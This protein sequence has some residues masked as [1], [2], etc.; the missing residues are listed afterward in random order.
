MFVVV[1]DVSGKGL[2]ASF[3]MSKIQTMI[4][5]FSN[6]TKSPKE[7]LV[8]VN[9]KIFGKISKQSFITM[10]I[11]FIDVG[12]RSMKLCRAG[13]TPIIKFNN[14]VIQFIKPN[15]IGV[16]LENGLIFEESL[17]EIEIPLSPKDIFVFS[18]DGVNEA[19][20]DNNDLFGYD[21]LIEVIKRNSNNSSSEIVHATIKSIDKF[22]GLKDPSDDVTLVVMKVL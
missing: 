7:V 16:G 12:K 15:G 3:Y 1:G 17:E 22:R 9:K 11:A 4:Q 8:E 2:S 10:N 6:E 14:G 21:E 19:M 13:H 20:N 18:S 5:L